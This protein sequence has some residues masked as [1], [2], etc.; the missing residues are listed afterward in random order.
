MGGWLW[1]AEEL[2][3]EL[4][5]KPLQSQEILILPGLALRL[6]LPGWRRRFLG[7]GRG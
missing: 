4:E 7:P 6:I 3:G 1:V 5:P 2:R